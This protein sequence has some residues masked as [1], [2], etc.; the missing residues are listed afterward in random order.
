MNN[1]FFFNIYHFKGKFGIDD[2]VVY[3]GRCVATELCDFETDSCGYVNNI[4]SDINWEVGN[5]TYLN[6]TSGLAILD[7]T[8]KD[9]LTV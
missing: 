8:I 5:G 6:Q 7:V 9:S 3:E 1:L 4:A 2:I